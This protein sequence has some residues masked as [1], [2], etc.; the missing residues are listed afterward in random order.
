M[1]SNNVTS[2]IT[3]RKLLAKKTQNE[4]ITM[5]TAYDC[6]TA[7]ILDRSG[8]DL[9]LVGDSL[10]NVVLGYDTTLPVTLDDM[11]RHTSAVVRSTQNA[12]VILDLPFGTYT[13][14]QRA[15]RSGVRALQESGCQ[16]VKLEGGM[17]MADTVRAL[18]DHGIPV[19]CHIGL[20]PQ[21]VHQ[22]GGYRRHGKT[23]DEA[24]VLIESALALEEAGAFSVVL[25]CVTEE[26]AREIS[27]SLQIP[28]IGIGSGP[29]CDGQVLV[30]NDLIGLSVKPPPSF[31][32]PRA[33]VAEII[34]K[35]ARDFINEVKK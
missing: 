15:V 30:I 34:E 16:A 27:K 29:N 6:V 10:G 3:T 17:I 1:S 22:Q 9:L 24:R 32:K 8:I 7:A 20:T 35:T 13:S 12:L 4:K 23:L 11:I 31:A 18:C 2:R 25:E 19:M 21:S 14:P 33:N 5:L 28:T 26:L